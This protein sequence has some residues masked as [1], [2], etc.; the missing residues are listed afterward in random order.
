MPQQPRQLQR[1]YANRQ[2]LIVAVRDLTAAPTHGIVS[3]ANNGLSPGGGLAEQVLQEAGPELAAECERIIQ[4][5]GKIPTTHAVLTGA[6]RLPYRGILHA[7]G[8]RV[9]EERVKEKLTAT[10]QNCLT[11]AARLGWPSIALPAISTGIFGVPRRL[12][13]EALDT[14]VKQYF[15]AESS[16]IDEIWLC[17]TLDAFDEFTAVLQAA[18]ARYQTPGTD[19]AS[20]PAIGVVEVDEDKL[21]DLSLDDFKFEQEKDG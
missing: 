10:F 12:C 8:P 19:M 21:A 17:L 5:Q 15:S 11:L 3:P 7:V 4:T 2:R 20:E 13:A 14:A 1:T 6:G 16:V 18:E 9:V